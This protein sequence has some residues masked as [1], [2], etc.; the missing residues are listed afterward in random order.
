MDDA[1]VAIE[2][3]VD[4][5]N[6]FIGTSSYLRNYSHGKDIHQIEEAV[7]EV[8]EYIKSKGIEVRFST[9]DSF[10]SRLQD[11]EHLY[12]IVDKIGVARVGISDTVGIASPCQVYYLVKSVR[13]LVACDIEVHLHNDTGCAIAN[14]YSALEAGAT[15][16]DT[17]VL[18]IGER[19]GITSLG[20]L[21]ARLIVTQRRNIVNRFKIK[22]LRELEVLVAKAVNVDIPFNNVVTGFCAFSHKAGIHTKAVLNNPQTYEAID[23]TDFGISRSISYASRLTG[24]NTIKH[25]AKQLGIELSDSQCKETT[26]RIKG[27]AD[28]R[29]V[30]AADVD[31]ALQE[32]LTKMVPNSDD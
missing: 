25:R 18:G 26:A 5:I 31:M 16:V 13:S 23:P 10:R 29:L 11:I 14:A 12:S 6:I 4:G 27:L 1:K 15:H 19:N 8:I 9:E 3:G 17:S 2:T 20:G 21:I 22:K 30:S 28:I 32:S 7:V 24:W